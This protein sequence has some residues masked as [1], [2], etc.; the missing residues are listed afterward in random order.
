M[1]KLIFAFKGEE[2][3]G[4]AIGESW[5][6]SDLEGCE[7]LVAPTAGVCRTLLSELCRDHAEALLGVACSTSG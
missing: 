3:R 7:S 5:E 6:V 1:A 2:A 4:S